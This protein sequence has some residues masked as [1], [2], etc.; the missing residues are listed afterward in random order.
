MPADDESDPQTPGPEENR[1]DSGEN[2]ADN[3]LHDHHGRFDRIDAR[4]DRLQE[5]ASCSLENE[6]HALGGLHSEMS[7]DS[8]S[9]RATGGISSQRSV[10]D[11]L[12]GGSLEVT[13]LKES[14][15]KS[16]PGLREWPKDVAINRRS[17]VSKT[18]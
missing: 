15:A 2:D 7:K 12:Q 13:A 5:R 3:G 17:Q 1:G 9:N 16:H 4:E 6:H 8:L 10:F 14:P 11:G 18:L